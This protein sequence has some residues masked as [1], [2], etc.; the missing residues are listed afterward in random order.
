MLLWIRLSVEAYSSSNHPRTLA[1]R[2]RLLLL[3]AGGDKSI[4]AKDIAKALELNRKV[5]E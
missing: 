2:T 3:L 1:E 4:Q 5:V